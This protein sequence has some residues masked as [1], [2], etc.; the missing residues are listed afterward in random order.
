MA[1]HS[2]LTNSPNQYGWIS[3]AFHWSIAVGVI[4][5][6]AV[7]VW[8]VDLDYYSN[9]YHDAPFIH[10]SVGILVV[11]AMMLRWIWN[12]V[13]KPPQTYAG[14]TSEWARRAIH[15]MHLSLYLLVVLIGVSGY[16]I[17]TAEDQGIMVFNW[18]EVPA[19]FPAFENQADIMGDVHEWL[20]NILIGLV[21]LHLLGALKH[22]LW[23]KDNTLRRMLTPSAEKL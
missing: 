12:W 8:M 9:W 13:S 1:G 7:G 4:G 6:F 5:L 17:S 14:V 21:V 22:H 18:F 3:I 23:D 2:S 10:K 19:L 11:G 16:L 15:V 20:A